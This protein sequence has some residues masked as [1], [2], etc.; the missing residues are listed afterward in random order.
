[1]PVVPERQIGPHNLSYASI[2]HLINFLRSMIEPWPKRADE[3]LRVTNFAMA[4]VKEGRPRSDL[5]FLTVARDL[6]DRRIAELRTEP[7]TPTA[8]GKR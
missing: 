2:W 1:M 6:I 5:E 7:T 8:K 3:S 4:A